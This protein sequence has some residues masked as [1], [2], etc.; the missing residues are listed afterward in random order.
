MFLFGFLTFCWLLYQSFSFSFSNFSAFGFKL[1]LA[2]HFTEQEMLKWLTILQ[3]AAN[4]GPFYN[5]SFLVCWSFKTV[6]FRRLPFQALSF[7]HVI[8]FLSDVLRFP[9]NLSFAF[10]DRWSHV[11]LEWILKVHLDPF[12]LLWQCWQILR[13]LHFLSFMRSWKDI[14]ARIQRSREL[15]KTLPFLSSYFVLKKSWICRLD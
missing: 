9:K 2:R 11:F 8:F 1:Y 6:L 3:T 13:P 12:C 4:L 15:S 5:R 10:F 14:F 7:D